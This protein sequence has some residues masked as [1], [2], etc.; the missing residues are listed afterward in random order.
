MV[1]F[2]YGGGFTI[3]SS[4]LANYDGDALAKAGAV[5]VN[6]NYRVGALGF[7]A[8]PELTKEQAG[9][10]GNYGLMDQTLALQWVHDNITRFGGDPEKVVIMS[11]RRVLFRWRLRCW[12]LPRAGS[13]ARR[14]CPQAAICAGPSPR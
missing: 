2:I 7:L 12:R 13:S 3:G 4:S 1:I 9:A 10:S 6:F 8:D 14:S 11:N 5:F